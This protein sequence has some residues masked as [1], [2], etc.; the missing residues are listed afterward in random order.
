MLHEVERRR[1]VDAKRAVHRGYQNV[2]KY[3]RAKGAEGERRTSKTEQG[4]AA[5]WNGSNPKRVLRSRVGLT[6]RAAEMHDS[7]FHQKSTRLLQGKV[8]SLRACIGASHRCETLNMLE[9]ERL[10]VTVPLHAYPR[11]VLRVCHAC[12][13]V[14]RTYVHECEYASEFVNKSA[15]RQRAPVSLVNRERRD[16]ITRR[17]NLSN[18][19]VTVCKSSGNH[20]WT[21][22]RSEI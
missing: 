9:P 22:A 21:F 19:G 10:L 2:P 18:L 7:R 8:G 17:S 3:K 6:M 16:R 20:R 5:E 1:R 4:H 13:R 12:T 14:V 11:A 15:F